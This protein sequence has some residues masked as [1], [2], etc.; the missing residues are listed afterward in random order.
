MRSKQMVTIIVLL[1]CIA[2]VAVLLYVGGAGLIQMLRAHM[3][4]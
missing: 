2:L 1:V 3:G 4:G